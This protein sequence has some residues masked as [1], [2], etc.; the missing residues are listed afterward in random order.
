LSR[1]ILYAVSFEVLGLAITA[2][3]LGSLTGSSASHSLLLAL[4]TTE[5][6]LM[7]NMV[8]NALFE[9]WETRQTRKGRS[10]ARRTAHAV[11][12]EA[13]LSVLTTPVLALGLDLG[14][15]QAFLYDAALTAI[16][17][18]YTWVFTWGFDAIFGLPDSAK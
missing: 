18:I 1:R 15:R 8:F 16:F 4:V 12:F 3:A 6:A 5:I 17:M 13:G 14:L 10:P 7:W 2:L 11:L 9:A